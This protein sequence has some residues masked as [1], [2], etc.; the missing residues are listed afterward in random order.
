MITSTIEAPVV[1]AVPESLRSSPDFPARRLRLLRAAGAEADDSCVVLL[2]SPKDIE[3]FTGAHEGVSWMAVA[4]GWTLVVTRALMLHEVREVAHDCEVVLP[5]KHS[6][7][8]VD[9][10]GFVASELKRRGASQVVVEP[11]RMV[12]A[13]YLSL[14]SHAPAL[15]LHLQAMTGLTEGLRAI[16]DAG[17]LALIRRCAEIADEAFRQLIAGGASS[18]V[19]RTEREL[20]AELER[21][22]IALGADRQGFPET[23]IIVASGPNGANAHH[24][25]SHRRVSSGEGL[26][27][28]WGAEV[29]GYRS[30]MTRTIFIETVPAFAREAYPVVEEALLSAAALLRAGATMGEIDRA[31]RETVLRSGLP[32][33]HY[34]VGHGVGLDIHEGPWLRA[35]SEQVLASDMVTTI[36][37]GVY[38]PGTGGIRI[39]DL[40]HVLPTGSVPLGKLPTD[41]DAMILC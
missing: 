32:E 20:A 19:G 13:G 36:E 35:H 14:A 4:R 1:P 41:L 5:S 8:R 39:E 9:V 40:F 2:S 23:G 6:T 27:I 37:P 21:N 25:P 28:D 16:K 34:G 7:D 11:A 10:E 24:R 33:F 31:A 3:Y 29:S 30:D 22:M 17:E 18:L 26:L 12:A 15:G 38:V